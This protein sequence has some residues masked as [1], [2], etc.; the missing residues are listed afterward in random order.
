MNKISQYLLVGT[1][2]SLHIKLFKHY[3][4]FQLFKVDK[5]DMIILS[6]P[7]IQAILY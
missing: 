2:A 3:C 4:A 7:S 1:Q 5:S 6:F